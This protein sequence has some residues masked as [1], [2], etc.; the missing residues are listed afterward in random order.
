MASMGNVAVRSTSMAFGATTSVMIESSAGIQD[1]VGAKV[2]LHLLHCG[3]TATQRY[4][5]K[6]DEIA[7]FFNLVARGHHPQV[8][9]RR[10]RPNNGGGQAPTLRQPDSPYY[11]SNFIK[12]TDQP[13][14]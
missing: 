12:V 9:T 6:F 4:L 14:G 10:L 8:G 5:M 13:W 3:T 7:G 2:N 1:E 11:S